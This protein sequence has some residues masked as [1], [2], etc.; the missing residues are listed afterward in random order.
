MQHPSILQQS[1]SIRSDASSGKVASPP[2]PLPAPRSSSRAS[3]DISPP[4]RALFLL[5]PRTLL[6]DLP[7]TY[8]QRSP[9]YAQAEFNDGDFPNANPDASFRHQG[10][11]RL[12]C[13]RTRTESRRAVPTV[14]NPPLRHP[15][16]TWA[17]LCPCLHAPLCLGRGRP[18]SLSSSSRQ[19][20]PLRLPP[21]DARLHIRVCARIFIIIL[22]ITASR[23]ADMAL[24]S[25][26]GLARLVLCLSRMLDPDLAL[27]GRVR[28]RLLRGAS[29]QFGP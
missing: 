18:L 10:E 12:C 24:V 16:P 1:R 28:D 8:T 19:S 13:A 3:L 7:E 11:T 14:R 2:A 5:R 23:F 17:L 22:R 27:P 25:I 29:I 6:L 4:Y 15:E 9:E 21:W 20:R 26:S